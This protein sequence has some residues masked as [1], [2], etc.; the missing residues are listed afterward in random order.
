MKEFR[1]QVDAKANLDHSQREIAA[2]RY[3]ML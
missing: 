2:G 3:M 1:S